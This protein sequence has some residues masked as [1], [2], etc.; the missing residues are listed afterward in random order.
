MPYAE[1]AFWLSAPTRSPSSQPPGACDP[2]IRAAHRP[3][4]TVVCLH[5]PEG[6]RNHT[7]GG[8]AV[9]LHGASRAGKVRQQRLSPQRPWPA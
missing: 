3:P 5:R 1:A 9:V 7:D 4:H 2:R 6:P 8:A